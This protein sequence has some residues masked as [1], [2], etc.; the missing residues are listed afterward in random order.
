MKEHLDSPEDD[1]LLGRPGEIKRCA[2]SVG[3]TGSVKQRQSDVRVV[4]VDQDRIGEDIDHRD[5]P[6]ARRSGA[7]FMGFRRHMYVLRGAGAG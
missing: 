6:H 5:A 1:K 3:S 2:G 7:L 4:G